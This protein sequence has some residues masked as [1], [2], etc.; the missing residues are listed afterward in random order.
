MMMELLREFLLSTTTDCFSLSP[1][2]S[3]LYHTYLGL[4]VTLW[5]QERAQER[6]TLRW[7]SAPTKQRTCLPRTT[8]AP[9]ISQCYY[10][11]HTSIWIFEYLTA[12]RPY[13]RNNKVILYV[14]CKCHF[15]EEGSDPVTSPFRKEN[16]NDRTRAVGHKR[17]QGL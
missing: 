6:G 13:T 1:V 14:I 11:C 4:K 7:S 5:A 12:H 16:A 9:Q 17:G 2:V 8:R 15:P 10:L 3:R